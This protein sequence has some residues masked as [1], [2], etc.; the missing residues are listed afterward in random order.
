[1]VGP[2]TVAAA[3]SMVVVV[4]GERAVA[5]GLSARGDGAVGLRAALLV[6]PP[7]E[8]LRR[9][10]WEIPRD[11]PVALLFVGVGCGMM[12]PWGANE[13]L[14]LFGG[15]ESGRM[16]DGGL[17]LLLVVTVTAVADGA[18]GVD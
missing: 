14:L 4:L 11:G 7:I 9:R 15:R 2:A 5:G 8:R 12:R 3:A 13:R 17:L 6:P 18:A 16:G 10:I 1:M